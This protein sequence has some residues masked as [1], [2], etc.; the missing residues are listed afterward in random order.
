R[1]CAAEV[2]DAAD[3]ERDAAR[4]QRDPED[5][6][7]EPNRPGRV[8]PERPA[9]G[10]DE[11]QGHALNE[12]PFFP[13]GTERRHL[14]NPKPRLVELDTGIRGTASSSAATSPN[15]SRLRS[16]RLTPTAPSLAATTVAAS[17]A[18]A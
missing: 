2:G 6:P 12:D 7:H 17:R 1:H 4:D 8:R 10:R 18:A 13:A 9:G 5:D 11:H 15:G 3:D 16:A 14:Y